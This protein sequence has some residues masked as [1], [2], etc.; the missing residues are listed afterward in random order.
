VRPPIRDPLQRRKD[1]LL[2]SEADLIR[3]VD[4]VAAA[5][6]TN[7]SHVINE[8]L[9]AAL[10]ED[11]PLVFAAIVA[12][13]ATLAVREAVRIAQRRDEAPHVPGADG[14]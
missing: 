14:R 11:A 12:G 2:R 7:R 3:T 9:P 5:Y 10:Q 1:V 6:G 13:G 4:A 8:F